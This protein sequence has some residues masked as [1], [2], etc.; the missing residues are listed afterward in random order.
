MYVNTLVFVYVVLIY[1]MDAIGV[2]CGVP[3]HKILPTPSAQHIVVLP[4][5]GDPQ[6]WHAMSNTL[7]H[8]FKGKRCLRKYLHMYRSTP[9]LH[10]ISVD[11]K[12]Y[13]KKIMIFIKELNSVRTL[14]HVKI[15]RY[16]SY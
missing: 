13:L 14:D 6:L 1:V 4:L 8:T 9:F 2:N 15:N 7:V 5:S 12:I 11:F 3:V 10:D 16:V